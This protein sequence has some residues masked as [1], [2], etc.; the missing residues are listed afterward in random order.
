MTKREKKNPKTSSMLRRK[1]RRKR[2]AQQN[3]NDEL[4]K[5]KMSYTKMKMKRK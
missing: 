3:P 5:H 4:L 2:K 1:R